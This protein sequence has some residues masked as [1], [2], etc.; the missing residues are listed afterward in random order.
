MSITM[1]FVKEDGGAVGITENPSALLRWITSGPQ[2]SQLIK[3]FGMTTKSARV[4]NN[5]HHLDIPS[6]HKLFLKM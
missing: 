2:I 4:K 3:G 5:D 6:S 1:P